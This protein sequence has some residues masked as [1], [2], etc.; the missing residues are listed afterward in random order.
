MAGR[1]QFEKD[2]SWLFKSQLAGRP[3]KQ[4]RFTAGK[5]RVG[6]YYGRYAGAGGGERKF[7]DVTLDDAV[8]SSGGTVTDS[9]N[10]IGQ[11]VTEITRIGRKCTLKEIHWKY[12]VS[13]PEVDAVADPAAVG[14]VRTIMYL[15]KQC[16]GATAAVTDIL[17]TDD[18]Q[19]FYNLANQGR[20]SIIMDKLH[21]LNYM[22]MA[23]DGAALVSMGKVTRNYSFD[24][25]CN[26]PL[27]FDNTTGAITEIRSNN[28]GVLILSD[29]GTMG[30][31]S[32]IRIRFSDGAR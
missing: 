4:R 27:E 12:T 6:G 1:G 16:N 32:N 14:T 9:I 24:K 2:M 18:Y 26:I 25:R 30:F 21:T 10:K 28:V 15:D 20:F 7:K 17:E 3:Y 11:G 23:S 5:D 19:S 8:V 13:L 31:T 22:T 29:T